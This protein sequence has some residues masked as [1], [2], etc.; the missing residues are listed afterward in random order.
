M[1][2]FVSRNAPVKSNYY[3]C[4]SR[5]VPPAGRRPT[6]ILHHPYHPEKTD[7]KRS[8]KHSKRTPIHMPYDEHVES[9]TIGKPVLHDTSW[10]TCFLKPQRRGLP[11]L[12]R[13][14]KSRP[15]K[16]RPSPQQKPHKRKQQSEIHSRNVSQIRRRKRF[17]PEMRHSFLNLSALQ[18]GQKQALERLERR[19]SSA[20]KDFHSH[21]RP[22]SFSQ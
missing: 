17:P 1:I 10:K 15:M 9:Q 2:L 13:N 11:K 3:F 5:A 7:G 4:R 8:D 19:P 21:S 6:G 22:P 18:A 14:R 20:S 16:L 12:H